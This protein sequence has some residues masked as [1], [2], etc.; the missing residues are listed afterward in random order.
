MGRPIPW[1]RR[2]F[3]V[4]LPRSHMLVGHCERPKVARQSI[5][6]RLGRRGV[7]D[8]RVASLLAMTGWWVVGFPHLSLRATGGRAAIHGE[9]VRQTRRSKRSPSDDYFAT[10]HTVSPTLTSSASAQMR[11]IDTVSSSPK[12][13]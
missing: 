11:S 6:G 10:L 5:V 4:L 2:S 7:V 3:P 1:G 12:S 9:I 13:R 8:R